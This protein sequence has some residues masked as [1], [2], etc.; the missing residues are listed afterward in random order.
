MFR[1]QSIAPIFK[2]G[3]KAIA[4]NY[5]P[6]SLTSHLI[7]LFERIARKKMV[8]FIETNN[9]INPNQHGFQKGKNCLTQLLHHIEDIMCDLCADKNA[10]VMYLDF[11]KAF[12]KVDHKILLKKLKSFGIQGKLYN[13]IASF[14]TGRKPYV[15]VDGVMSSIIDVVSGVPQGTVLG[16]LLFLI[17]INDIFGAVK[18]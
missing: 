2:K 8:S 17:Y 6:V 11:S 4:A 16:P 9:L 12:D 5:R 13:W 7:K 15:T 18:Q 14:L 1:T 10:D 3:S